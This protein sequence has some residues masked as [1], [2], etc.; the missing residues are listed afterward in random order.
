LAKVQDI[1]QRRTFVKEVKSL[2]LACRHFG[3]VKRRAK[4]KKALK[5][6]RTIA[7]ILLR[8][9]QRKLPTAIREQ[10][11]ERFT[12][13]QRVIDQRPKDKNKVYNLHESDVYCVGKGKDHKQ[14]EYGRKASIVSTKDSNNIVGVAS[15]DEHVHDSK[16]LK[17]ALESAHEHRDKPIKLA[18]VDR[19][20][21]GAKKHIPADIEILLPSPPLK[22]DTAYQRKEA[23]LMSK[24]SR[25]RADHRLS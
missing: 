1:Q 7:G 17:S 23:N 8:E 4:A 3:H 19:G 18:V 11:E 24:A 15:H 6:S 16:T 21:R 20:Y 25:H 14:Y 10:E 12:L 2:R 22:R 13:Y 5:R 9:L